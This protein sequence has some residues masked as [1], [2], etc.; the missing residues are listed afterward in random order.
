M[1]H[2][3]HKNIVGQVQV[4]KGM[5]IKNDDFKLT[6]KVRT[7]IMRYSAVDDPVERRLL[8]SK[9]LKAMKVLHKNPENS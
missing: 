6:K 2:D 1:T 7:T 9:T 4:K 3:G 8:E 5:T